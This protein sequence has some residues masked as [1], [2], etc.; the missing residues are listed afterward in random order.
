MASASTINSWSAKTPLYFSDSGHITL[1]IK[2]E[3]LNVFHSI[4]CYAMTETP[5]WSPSR[6]KVLTYEDGI[7]WGSDPY[8]GTYDIVLPE[9]MESLFDFNSTPKIDRVGF[10]LWTYSNSSYSGSSRIGY[11]HREKTRDEQKT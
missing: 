6:R 7:K 1:T 10:E 4:L 5:D 8:Y 3:D 9:T 11:E 2:R